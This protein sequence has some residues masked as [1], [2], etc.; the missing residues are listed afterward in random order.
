M[1][2]QAEGGI[3]TMV[4]VVYEV[5]VWVPEGA[6]VLVREYEVGELVVCDVLVNEGLMYG[7]LEYEVLM[8]DV[9]GYEVLVCEV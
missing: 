5:A 1:K 4:S 8:C 9:L 7:A 3:V 2:P 6:W